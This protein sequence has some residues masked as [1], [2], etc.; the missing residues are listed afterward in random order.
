MIAAIA[1]ITAL[2][3]KILAGF[4]AGLLLLGVVGAVAYASIQHLTQYCSDRV[5]SLFL[6]VSS[7][8]ILFD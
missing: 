5:N 2:E 3:I 6:N 1:K 4:A 7:H 8:Y